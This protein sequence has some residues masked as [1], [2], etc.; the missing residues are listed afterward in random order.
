MDIHNFIVNEETLSFESILNLMMQM[1]LN[2]CKKE[3]K[4][5]EIK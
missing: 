5:F 3:M 2:L 4:R 1:K